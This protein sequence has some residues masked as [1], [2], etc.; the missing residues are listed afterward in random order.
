MSSTLDQEKAIAGKVNGWIKLF[1]AIQK[2]LSKLLLKLIVI[3]IISFPVAALMNFIINQSF[4]DFGKALT[5]TFTNT[6]QFMIIYSITFIGFYFSK[7][8]LNALKA[9]AAPKPPAA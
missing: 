6:G 8:V 5:D 2:V 4:P 3:G 1:Q 7:M 9:V